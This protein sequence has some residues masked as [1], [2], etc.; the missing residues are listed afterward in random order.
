MIDKIK[1]IKYI[2]LDTNKFNKK[3]YRHEGEKLNVKTG[4]IYP[5]DYYKCK[6]FNNISVIYSNKENTLKIEGRLINANFVNNKVLNFDDYIKPRHA[7]IY[8][9]ELIEHGERNC[10]DANDNLCFSDSTELV[11][12]E[13]VVDPESIDDMIW[14]VNRKINELLGLPVIEEDEFDDELGEL[15]GYKVLKP[16]SQIDIRDFKVLNIEICF[17]IW[18]KKDYVKEYIMLFNKIFK[19]R[20]NKG[21]KNHTLEI[22][23]NEYTSYYVKTKSSYDKNINDN[24]TVNFYNKLDQLKKTDYKVTQEDLRIADSCLRLEVQL[25]NKAI[26]RVCD[27]HKIENTFNS[28]LNLDLCLETLK[29][30]YD[31][32]IDDAEL[33]FYSYHNAKSKI[34]NTEILSIK[35][36]ESLLNYI[37]EKYQHNKIHSIQTKNKYN[38]ML[39]KLNVSEFFI[40]TSY[41]INFMKSPMKLLNQKLSYYKMMEKEYS[42]CTLQS[43]PIEEFKSY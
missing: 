35:D 1:I 14:C 41:D 12:N 33:D 17:N 11:I 7:T 43:I 8:E 28:F 34:E 2:K 22:K 9:E 5:I 4:E 3:M 27:K 18:L 19:T 21:Y 38:K 6:I 16:K 32:F 25:Y 31:R 42:E 37:K 39:N 23:E 13:Y 26:T 29:Y 30:Y 24:Y 40:P 10:Y 20:N 15:L 36:K